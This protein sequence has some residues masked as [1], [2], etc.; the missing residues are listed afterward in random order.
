MSSEPELVVRPMSR[1]D[2]DQAVAWAAAEG[3][4]PGLHDAD[5]FWATDPEGY[6]RADLDGEM[7]GKELRGEPDP[8]L[9]PLA[10]VPE[11]LLLAYDRAHFPV[12]RTEFLRRWV[13]PRGGLA[14][15]AMAEDGAAL[16]GYGV[17]RPCQVGYKV[18]PLFADTPEVAD[19]LFRSLVAF[20]DGAEVFLDAPE[21]N[22]AAL[23]LAARYELHEVF[24]CARMV[25]GPA[26]ELPLHEVYG[27]TT[28]ELG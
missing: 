5:V 14:L 6:V 26:P 9:A 4:N 15:G 17:I 21:A 18:G 16:A 22:P 12:E 28:F 7:V 2:L 25:D 19:R 8:S 20:A 24:G 23:A 10:D 11:E 3:W 27:V 1:A 13:R